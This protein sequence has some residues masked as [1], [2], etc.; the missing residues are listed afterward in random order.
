MFFHHNRNE[1][2]LEWTIVRQNSNGQA[3]I[4]LPEKIKNSINKSEDATIDL[5]GFRFCASYQ[6]EDGTMV[7]VPKD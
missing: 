4:V 5:S 3:E 2:P 6:L 1:T 7:Y